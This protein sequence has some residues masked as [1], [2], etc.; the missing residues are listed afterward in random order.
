[1]RRHGNERP[2]P[3]HPVAEVAHERLATG[4][5]AQVPPES[6]RR[7]SEATHAT[8]VQSLLMMTDA[9]SHQIRRVVTS[10]AGAEDD[11]MLVQS[12]ARRAPGRLA[13]PTVALEDAVTPP[14]VR[15]LLVLP[16]V[17]H[18]T[19][20]DQEAFPVFQVMRRGGT[21]GSQGAV[22]EGGDLQ[23]TPEGDPPRRSRV[24]CGHR[25]RVGSDERRRCVPARGDG[26][27][28]GGSG[29]ERTVRR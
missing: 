25:D 7:L 8:L 18:A 19:G 24:A 29:T 27:W 10:L 20:E 3:D 4:L 9:Q 11:V 2:A 13:A 21:T 26:G 16:G 15:V 22:P 12:A 6:V 23:R 28:R 14:P 1:G 5:H 17:A